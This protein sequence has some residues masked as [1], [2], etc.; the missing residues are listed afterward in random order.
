VER[1]HGEVKDCKSLLGFQFL[2]DRQVNPTG[3]RHAVVLVQPV[4]AGVIDVQNLGKRGLFGHY[5]LHE[6]FIQHLM[7][8][9]EY[10]ILEG[11]LI[12]SRTTG[13]PLYSC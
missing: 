12:L 9:E 4:V 3:H 5:A 6:L 13:M 2:L 10:L 7:I 11:G 8:K 1:R